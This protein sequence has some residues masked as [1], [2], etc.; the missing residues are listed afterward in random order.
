VNAPWTAALPLLVP[1]CTA[2]LTAAVSS[3]P[4]LQS[5]LSLGG[6]AA[7]VCVAVRLLFLTSEAG[8]VATALGGWA[9]PFGVVLAID[10]AGALLIAV[11][12]ATTLACLVFQ[13]SGVDAPPSAAAAPFATPL[14]HGLLAGVCGAFSAGDLFNLYVWFEL[15][16]VCA[17]GLLVAAGGRAGLD[18]AAKY[19][20][21]NLIATAVLL[22][23]VA[24]VYAATGHLNFDALR[25][26]LAALPSEA[27]TPAVA[28]VLVAF[29]A[30]AGAFPCFAWLPA[31]YPTLPAPWLALFAGLLTKTGVYG[32][33]RL[34]GDVA[35]SATALAEPL[36]WIACATMLAGALGAVRHYDLRRIL[37]FHIVSQIGYLLLGVAVG[38]DGGAAATLFYLAHH[39][40]VKANLF[41]V[42]ALIARE[43]GGYDLRR[44]GG[45][46][47][48]SVVLAVL[49][50][51]P[52]LSLAG[53]PP[54]S[55]F[56][57]KFFVLR[58]ALAAGRYAW[59]VAA[60]AAG[61]LTLYSMT[62]IWIEAFWKPRPDGAAAPSSDARGS[63]IGRAS[64]AALA[65]LTVWMGC[66]PETLTAFVRAA[67][68]GF[69]GRS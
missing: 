32:A 11:A 1:L 58:E 64:S 62:K 21:L 63:R 13:Q 38:G 23:G 49:F 3:R 5:A 33:L 43:A 57:A 31:A 30:K 7:A 41:L 39:I 45:L 66:A 44:T 68:A 55:G 29:L 15:S 18:A 9:E 8:R 16:L 37:S 34:L 60:L 50:A 26:A 59:T 46:F 52:A 6:A 48:R 47:P 10:R 25:P 4:R 24:L 12:A 54:L 51:V 17:L 61:A 67:A 56:W 22:V 20:V 42:A 2:L 19:L 53:V 40:V 65:A 27:R 69:G 28:I 35:P 14:V 36:G